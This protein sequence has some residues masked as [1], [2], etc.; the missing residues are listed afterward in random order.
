MLIFTRAPLTALSAHGRP[1]YVGQF[2]D[3][4]HYR[5]ER[6]V[7]LPASGMYEL[8]GP[9]RSSCGALEQR[10]MDIA[11]S[12]QRVLEDS[13]LEIVNRLQVQTAQARLS[14]A[15]HFAGN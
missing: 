15:G 5:G 7:E 6:C 4:L 3:L 8:L 12:L 13:M 11:H 9:L 10:H 14:I 1:G 2:R